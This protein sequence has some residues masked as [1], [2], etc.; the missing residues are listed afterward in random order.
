MAH[1]VINL[2]SVAAMNI[3]SYNRSV[4]CTSADIENGS[5]LELAS[6]SATAGLEEVW[7]AR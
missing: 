1:G 2:D 5:L 7:V 6:K 3:D 4:I